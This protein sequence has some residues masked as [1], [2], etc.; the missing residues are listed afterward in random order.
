VEILKKKKCG[1]EIELGTNSPNGIDWV[2]F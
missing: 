2:L 1:C